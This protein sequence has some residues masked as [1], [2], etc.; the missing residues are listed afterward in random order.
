MLRLAVYPR[1]RQVG[2]VVYARVVVADKDMDIELSCHNPGSSK[3][4]VTQEAVYGELAGHPATTP[5]H[6]THSISVI[7]D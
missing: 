4:W 5:Y 1:D 7:S 2:T 3:S 6:I